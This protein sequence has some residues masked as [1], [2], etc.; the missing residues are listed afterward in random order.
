MI[1]KISTDREEKHIER[2]MMMMR[3]A[4]R[5]KERQAVKREREADE[6]DRRKEAE[7]RRR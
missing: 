5:E 7:E 3:W 4:R 1:M 6:R 2:E